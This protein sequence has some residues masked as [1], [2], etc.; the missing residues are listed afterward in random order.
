MRVENENLTAE[1]FAFWKWNFQKL[2]EA[3]LHSSKMKILI[4]KCLKTKI[5]LNNSFIFCNFFEFF[6][7]NINYL[8]KIL[9]HHPKRREKRKTCGGPSYAIFKFK[10]KIHTRESCKFRS[11]YLSRGGAEVLEVVRHS[12]AVLYGYSTWFCLILACFFLL[13]K[14]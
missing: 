5:F 4:K 3:S 7:Q 10:M 1:T 12:S 14:A 9:I 2:N 6:T 11:K 8:I 13:F